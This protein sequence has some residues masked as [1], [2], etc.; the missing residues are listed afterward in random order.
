MRAD[1]G[2]EVFGVRDYDLRFIT[3]S[4]ESSFQYIF[5]DENEKKYFC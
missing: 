5:Q 2:E 1:I 3:D 4:I